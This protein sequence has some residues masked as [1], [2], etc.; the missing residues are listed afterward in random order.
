MDPFIGEI[1]MWGCN[2]APVGWAMCDGS[3]IPIQNNEA[4]YSLIGTIYGGDG[5][6]TFALP[7]LRGR[8]PMHKSPNHALGEK[9]GTESVTLTRDQLPSHNHLPQASSAGSTPGPAGGV[10]A[11]SAALQFASPNSPTQPMNPNAVGMAGGSQPH[12]NM[13]PFQALT[14]VIALEGIYP[15]RP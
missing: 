8:V 11:N 10:W 14:F 7:D 3:Q 2:F 1:K 5:V 9:A 4:L 13:L 12:D 6:N 15:Q